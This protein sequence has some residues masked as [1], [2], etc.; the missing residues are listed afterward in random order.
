MAIFNALVGAALLFFGRKVFWLFVAGAG[1]VAGM[2]LTA[3]TFNGSEL[4]SITVGLIVGL[5]AALLAVFVQRFAIGLA[6]FLAGGFI[7]LQILPMLNLEGGWVPWLAFVLGG[8]IGVILVSAVLDWA[9]IILSALAGASL[10][11][12]SLNPPQA[13]GVI[14]FIILVA[15]GVLVQARELKS[16]ND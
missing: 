6:G 5:I 10:L 3:S 11:I 4:M 14:A 8:I 12:G 16:E 7:A 13:L 1:F 15:V 9:L 2:S